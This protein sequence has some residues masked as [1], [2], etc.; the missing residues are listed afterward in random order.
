MRRSLA[1]MTLSVAYGGA[2]CGGASS[3]PTSD[4]TGAATTVDATTTTTSEGTTTTTSS[5]TGGD[6]SSSGTGEP[7]DTTDAIKLD[8]GLF[9]DLGGSE[10]D[11]GPLDESTCELAAQSLTS[12]GCLFA[13]TVGSTNTNLPWAVVAANTSGVVA[14]NVTLFDL[15]GALIESASIEPGELYTFVLAGDS[16]QLVGHAISSATQITDRVMRLESDIPVVAYQFSPYSSSQVATADASLLLPEHAWG[17]DHLVASYHNS[18][19]SDSWFTVVSL[20]DDNEITIEMPTNMQGVTSA[21]GP[22][23]SLG[24]G[25]SHTLTLQAGEAARIVSP[26]AGTADFTGARVTSTEPVALVTGSP[27]MSL[28]GPGM[29]FYKDYLEEQVPPRTAWGTEIPVVKFR[30][31]SDEPDLYRVMADADD[32]DVTITGGFMDRITL[33][34]GEVYEFETAEAFVVTASDAVLVSHFMESQDQASGPKNDAEYPGE[35]ISPNCASPSQLTTELGD[36]A[37]S[38]VAPLEQHRYNYT[39]L[40]PQTYAWDMITVIAP[41]AG[42]GSIVLDGDPLP[43]PTDIP[44]SDLGFARFLI[45]DGPHDIRSPT[46]RFGLEVYGYDCRISYAYP[47]GMSLG[48]IN[49]PEG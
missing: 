41:T 46:T 16:P 27:S 21:G 7:A 15:G 35:F 17:T 14:A 29:N 28:P 42:W 40:T 33:D 6:A 13:P 1:L 19:F 25:E 18:D 34:A 20:V 43:E 3:S 32:T 38:F 36:P 22:I 30:P 24:A 37:I 39:F 10:D 49:E 9:P 44:G 48:E 23:P 47:G 11:T 4:T 8:L 45:E 26:G 12:A 31:R 2:A 5:A